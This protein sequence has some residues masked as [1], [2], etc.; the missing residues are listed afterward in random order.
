MK[1]LNIFLLILLCPI[2][3]L[4]NGMEDDKK[5]KKKKKRGAATEIRAERQIGITLDGGWNTPGA[6]GVLVSYYATPRIGIDGGVGFGV[7][8]P[9][10]GVRGKYMLSTNNFAPYVGLGLSGKLGRTQGIETF[11]TIEDPDS[12][13]FVNLPLTYNTNR[14][15]YIQPTIGFE[16]MSNGGFV[17]GLATGYSI[18][19]TAPYE[20]TQN[21]GPETDAALNLIFGNGII[22]SFN[23]GYAF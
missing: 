1:K 7:K 19:A 3:L 10:L 23:I 21:F 2:L 15:L 8:G 20:F 18:A 9:K 4:A 14:A 16:F 12:G 6:N 5:R 22:L 11:E 17:V 13:L